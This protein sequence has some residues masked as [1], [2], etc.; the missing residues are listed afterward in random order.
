M[1]STG[2]SMSFIGFAALFMAL[3]RHDAEWQAYEVGQV[4]CIVL[5]GLVTLF[6]GLLVIPISSLTGQVAG[7]RV[8]SVA[9]LAIA[10]YMHQVRVGT[11]W[12]RWS[13]IQNYTCRRAQVT[14]IAPFACVAVAD[15]VLL[16]L[17]AITPNQELFE[18]GLIM[19]LA[20]PALVFRLVVCE[21]MASVSH[22][23]EQP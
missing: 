12:L 22:R 18:L 8:V 5:Y 11:S 21:L 6:G 10:F 19:M 13:R 3:R 20:T 4:N 17:S 2:I 7:F 14:S 16:L 23:P 1:A 9:L 15:Q